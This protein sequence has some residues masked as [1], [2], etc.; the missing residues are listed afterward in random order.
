M[1]ETGCMDD[2][3]V[4]YLNFSTKSLLS[5]TFKRIKQGKEKTAEKLRYQRLRYQPLNAIDE[6]GRYR[7]V[8]GTQVK[9]VLKKRRDSTK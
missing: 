1:K 9:R 6:V 7:R 3:F 4:I 8:C 5:E 2:H